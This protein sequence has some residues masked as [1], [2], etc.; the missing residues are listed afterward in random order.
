VYI[1]AYKKAEQRLAQIQ[2]ERKQQAEERKREL[3]ERNRKLEENLSFRKKMN[4]VLKQRT[5]KGQPKL[6]NQMEM[7]LVKI[8]KRAGK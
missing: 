6:N 5:K 4:K 1:S 8:Q 7:L 3:E 2:A